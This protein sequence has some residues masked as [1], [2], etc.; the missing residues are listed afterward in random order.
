[1]SKTGIIAF[2]YFGG[3]ATWIEEL[4]YY[5]P[6]HNH[7]VDVFCGSMSVSL[8]KKPS[9]LDTANDIDSSIYNFFKVLR[10]RP[11]EL[12]RVLELTVVGRK[13][14]DNAWPIKHADPVEHARRFFVRCRM[15][16]QGSGL[17]KSTGFNAC[18]NSTEKS[19]SKNINKYFNS[20]EK[21]PLIIERLQNIQIENLDY[22]RLIKK[23]D[24][25][26]TFFYCDPPYELR[27]RSYKKYYTHEFEDKDH[28]EMVELL[29]NVSGKVMISGYE[30]KMYHELLKDWHFIQ[31]PKRNH[32]IKKTPQI[33][34]IWT[35]YDPFK[36]KGQLKLL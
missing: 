32:A 2:N 33:E 28:Y 8:N 20:I 31:L 30:S 36:E 4:I 26:E 22:Q 3:K 10:E 18:V 29:N 35:N 9:K 25:P 15:S 12:I 34:C 13:E 17:K 21:L 19:K 5:F 7:F 14:Y 11:E 1:M 24:V 27:K 23:Y 16:F 6:K